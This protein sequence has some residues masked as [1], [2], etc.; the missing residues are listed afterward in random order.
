MFYLRSTLLSTVIR[1][2]LVHNHKSVS[3]HI[4]TYIILH[5]HPHITIQPHLHILSSNILFRT[6]TLQIHH[7]GIHSSPIPF[8]TLN[9]PLRQTLLHPP[10]LPPHVTFLTRAPGCVCLSISL[11][12]QHFPL[13]LLT[14]FHSFFHFSQLSIFLPFYFPASNSHQDEA[15]KHLGSIFFFFV[16]L[17]F[18]LSLFLRDRNTETVKTL[19]YNFTTNKPLIQGSPF[20]RHV[21]LTYL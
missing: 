8:H 12:I 6:Y 3:S 13:P 18:F 16:L 11:F 2:T 21:V 14:F 20:S 5:L 15:T 1:L 9:T 4:A 17:S 19:K 7:H 10:T